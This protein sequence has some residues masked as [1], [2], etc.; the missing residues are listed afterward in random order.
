MNLVFSLVLLVSTAK[1]SREKAW[2][3]RS[4][5]HCFSTVC[6]RTTTWQMT[7]LCALFLT[8]QSGCKEQYWFGL[9]NSLL[10]GLSSPQTGK[11]LSCFSSLITTSSTYLM[12]W[13][14]CFMLSIKGVQIAKDNV[15]LPD[16]T[17]LC[18]ANEID[19]T[20]I[21]TTELSKVFFVD[22]R[23]SLL[24]PCHWLFGGW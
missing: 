2:G 16:S 9:S 4:L 22:I 1:A 18:K 7:N 19:S 10:M 12:S 24:Q 11:R 5:N 13:F 14:V 15:H 6:V 21:W 3:H 17:N 8:S 20:D 23:P